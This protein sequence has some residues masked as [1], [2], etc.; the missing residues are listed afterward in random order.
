MV[1][2]RSLKKEDITRVREIA[3]KSWLLTYKNI[4]TEEKIRKE[5]AEYYSKENFKK[6]QKDI[7]GGLGKFIVAIDNKIVG[8]AHVIKKDG[9]WEI[10]RIYL[11]PKF[12]RMGIGSG[13]IREV[14]KFLK[15]K[16][17]NK[18]LIYPHPKNKIVINFYKK[19]GFKRNPKLDRDRW[20]SPCFEKELKT[21]L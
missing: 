13:L 21:H 3:L 15:S 2:Y 9:V 11:D 8:Y 12:M 5:V 14:E 6:Y 16:N 19:V 17:V 1:E 20:C 10:I 7:K 4:F 18:Y